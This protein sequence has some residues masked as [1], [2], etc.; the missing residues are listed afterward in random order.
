MPIQAC[1]FI[2]T[3]AV[4]ASLD[5]SPILAGDI[6]GWHQANRYGTFDPRHE[7]V[8]KDLH[9]DVYGERK[10]NDLYKDPC[11]LFDL[12]QGLWACP[13]CRYAPLHYE[14]V[15]QNVLT[16]HV[17]YAGASWYRGIPVGYRK[18]IPLAGGEGPYDESQ[19]VP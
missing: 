14:T 9:E 13:G 5:I 17:P 1:V 6:I 8:W 3:L 2:V 16:P 15:R 19:R 18:E 4:V 10:L 12:G 7:D 11:D